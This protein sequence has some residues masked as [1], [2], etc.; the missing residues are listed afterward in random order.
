MRSARS[1]P[2]GHPGDEQ[3]H[4]QA[5]AEDRWLDASMSSSDISGDGI[6]DQV[7]HDLLT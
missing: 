2:A 6:V 4:A 1:V 5:L 3:R 7:S